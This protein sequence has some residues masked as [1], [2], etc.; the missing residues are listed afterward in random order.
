MKEKNEK[1]KIGKTN[2]KIHIQIH[3]Y[4]SRSIFIHQ[5]TLFEH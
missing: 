5:K 2:E 4:R 3:I 1:N